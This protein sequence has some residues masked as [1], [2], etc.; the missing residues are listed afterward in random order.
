VLHQGLRHQVGATA[1]ATTNGITNPACRR[2]A[3][4]PSVSYRAT[5]SK[6]TRCK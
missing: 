3:Q 5:T 6:W 4:I 1:T 2:G